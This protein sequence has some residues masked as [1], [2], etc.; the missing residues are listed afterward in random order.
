MPQILNVHALPSLVSPEE[1]AGGTV[2]VIDV[3]RACTTVVCALEAG[4]KE[5]APCLEI[6]QARELAET[7][8]ETMPAGSVVL[9]GERNGLPIDGFDLGNSPE[10]YAADRVGGKTLVFTTTNGTRALMQCG[11]AER[12]LLGAFVNASA[13]VEAIADRPEIHLIC[14]GTR[15]QYTQE[16]TLLAGLLV[17]RLQRRGGMMYKLNA[18][19]TVAQ[20][21]W[22]AAFAVPFAIGALPLESEKLAQ[23]LRK[24]LG[25]K[26]VVAIGM[27]QDIVAAAQI[28]RFSTVPQLDLKTFRIRAR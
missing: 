9:G 5:I 4:A 11:Q 12:V 8:T 13:V 27:D 18:Q 14:A 24:S 1:L 2:V 26:N 7:L 21:N 6:D 3:L 20:E 15:G 23:H 17:D 25:G 19:A 16:D 10:E 28:D 22:L